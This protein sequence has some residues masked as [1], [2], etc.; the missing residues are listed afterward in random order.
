[1][2]AFQP[3][4]R[5]AVPLSPH[6]PEEVGNAERNGDVLRARIL[7]LWR[8]TRPNMT[9]LNLMMQHDLIG[10]TMLAMHKGGMKCSHYRCRYFRQPGLCSDV[11]LCAH[12]GDTRMTSRRS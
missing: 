9:A 10:T 3:H 11:L 2:A 8:I 1:M 4:D 7:V 5:A 6:P 12:P